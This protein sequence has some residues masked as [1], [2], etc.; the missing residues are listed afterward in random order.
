VFT[1]T[2][3][4]AKRTAP[5]FRRIGGW[6]LARTTQA[7][8]LCTIPGVLNWSLMLDNG[9]LSRTEVLDHRLHDYFRMP[10]IQELAA[11]RGSVH[12]HEMTNRQCEGYFR[13]GLDLVRAR[14][15]GNCSGGVSWE[16]EIVV[17]ARDSRFSFC[18]RLWVS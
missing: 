3:W 17:S 18:I 14:A 15:P 1:D 16:N 7:E 2:R 4:G 13:I 9:R 5:E 10:V 11:E 6:P 12:F 8:E